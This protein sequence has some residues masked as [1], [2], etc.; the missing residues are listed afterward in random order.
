MSL[1]TVIGALLL[2]TPV[3]FNVTFAILARTFDYP[4]ILRRPT[5]EVLARFRAGGSRLILQ[6]WAFMLSGIL[7]LPV[8]VLLPNIMGG[9]GLL[10]PVATAVGILPLP[11]RSSDCCGGFTWFRT[12]R[13]CTQT[14]QPARPHGTLSASCSSR[15]T[16]SSASVLGSI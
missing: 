16:G 3:W 10:V 12:L 2:V 1:E 11:C 15:S 9:D 13:G 7:F 8:G 6:W 5:D 14:R 4:D